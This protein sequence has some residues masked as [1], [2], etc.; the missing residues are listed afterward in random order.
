M[1]PWRIKGGRDDLFLSPDS[2]SLSPDLSSRPSSCPRF[3]SCFIYLQMSSLNFFKLCKILAD[4]YQCIQWCKEH[5][6]LASSI[7]CPREDCNNTLTWTRRTS[8]RDGYEWRCSRRKCNSM[9]SVRQNS[10]F[11][12]SRLSIEKVLA[13]TYAWAHKFATTQ[14]VHET[15]R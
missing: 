3:N 9:A 7:K 11:S 2:Q 15:T 5:N 1:G 10:W 13:L 8:S 12:G 4:H 14:S 6:L